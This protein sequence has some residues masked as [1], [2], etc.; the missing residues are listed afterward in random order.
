MNNLKMLLIFLGF[1]AFG[2]LFMICYVYCKDNHLSKKQIY[3][4]NE[5]RLQRRMSSRKVH[6][7]TRDLEQG[8]GSIVF[9]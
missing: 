7:E 2:I 9:E 8:E 6:C 1:I 4:R 5:K 3:P